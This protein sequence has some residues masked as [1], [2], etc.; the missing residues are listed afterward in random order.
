MKLASKIRLGLAAKLAVCVIASTTA[1][2]ALFGYLNLRMAR[3]HSE[4]LVRQSA[5]RLANI[6]LRSTRYAMLQNDRNSLV[7][8]IRDLGSEPGIQR[9][10]IFDQNGRITL[11]TDPSEV[12]TSEPAG[13]A[14]VRRD[15]NGQRVLAVNRPIE[16]SKTCSN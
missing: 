14:G 16:N 1:F 2:F 11:S 7:G 4:A 9:I 8:I 3:N 10:R 12:G 6:M 5:D 13:P 15:P